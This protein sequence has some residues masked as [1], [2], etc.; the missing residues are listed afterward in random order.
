VRRIA[1]LLVAGYVH[2]PVSAPGGDRFVG[3]DQ[4]LRSSSCSNWIDSPLFNVYTA[5]APWGAAAT[6]G[7]ERI[8]AAGLMLIVVASC[9]AANAMFMS[10]ISAGSP[11][12]AATEM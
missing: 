2:A 4:P 12:Y 11:G 3:Q 9:D 6:P 5:G 7:P 1:A 8:A 10:N